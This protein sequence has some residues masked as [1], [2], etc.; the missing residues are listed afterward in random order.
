MHCLLFHKVMS[1][2][3]Q[4]FL[5]GVFL[6]Q[7]GGGTWINQVCPSCCKWWL[8]FAVSKF[9]T[10]FVVV[11]VP[12]KKWGELLELEKC[13]TTFLIF[14]LNVVWYM[15]TVWNIHLTV[16]TPGLFLPEINYFFFMIE[17]ILLISLIT[18]HYYF[19]STKFTELS[20]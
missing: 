14:I 5:C 10:I 8:L 20:S 12:R 1:S 16:L 2:Y 19:L 9:K 6:A 3:G 7:R 18:I 11:V 4:S 17:V 15:R 13:L